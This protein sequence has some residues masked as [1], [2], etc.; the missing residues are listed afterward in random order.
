MYNVIMK[1]KKIDLSATLKKYS[2]SWLALEPDTMKVVAS[3][4][5]AKIVLAQA[6]VAGVAHPLLTRAPKDYGTYILLLG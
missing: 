1:T 5:D 4:K 2:S 6:R 3:H